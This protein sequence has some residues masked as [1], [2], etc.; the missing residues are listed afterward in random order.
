MNDPVFGNR[1][2][3]QI[4]SEFKDY[5]DKMSDEEFNDI[6]KFAE[7]LPPVQIICPFDHENDINESS[8]TSKK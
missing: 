7:A 3:E 5:L 1:S 8:L 2:V 6:V 4:I